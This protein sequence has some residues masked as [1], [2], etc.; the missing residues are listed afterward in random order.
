MQ[1]SVELGGTHG[2]LS[3]A[4]KAKARLKS[5][6][7][8]RAR[9]CKTRLYTKIHPRLSRGCKVRVRRGVIIDPVADAGSGET[10]RRKSGKAE[11]TKIRGDPEIHSFGTAGRCRRRGNS[12]PHRRRDGRSETSGRLEESPSVPLKDAKFGATRKSIA[13][14]AGR[15]R[16]RGNS[17]PH[18]RRDRR[19]ETSGRPGD[20]PTVPLKDA[21]FGATRKSIA[22]AA[23]IA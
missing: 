10:R 4:W 9:M 7:Q 2:G 6:I 17:Q 11:G 16:R 21:K 5:C 19:S 20:S 13:G 18:R 8:G 12:Q 23:Q 3:A 1:V 14:T 15:C 22:G